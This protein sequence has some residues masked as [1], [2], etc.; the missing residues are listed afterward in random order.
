MEVGDTF[1]HNGVTYTVTAKNGDEVKALAEVDATDGADG[2]AP[3]R[4]THRRIC[5]KEGDITP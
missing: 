5:I 4:M 1:V 3:K 2:E